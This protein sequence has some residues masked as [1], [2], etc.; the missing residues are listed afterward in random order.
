MELCYILNNITGNKDIEE[1]QKTVY[2][3][4]QELK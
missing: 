3:I 2:C 1:I 4:V